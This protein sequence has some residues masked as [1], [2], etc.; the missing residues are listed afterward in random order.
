MVVLQNPFFYAL[1]AL[2]GLCMSSLWFSSKKLGRSWL[3][4]ATCVAIFA[5]GRLL[6]PMPFVIQPRLE[7]SGVI[8]NVVGWPLLI[9]G[10]LL[11]LTAALQIKPVTAPDRKEPLK[12]TGLYGIVRH[13]I[14]VGET[15]WPLGLS[16]LM[17]STIGMALTPFWFLCLYMGTRVEEEQMEELVGDEY[18]EYKRRVPGFIPFLK[19]LTT[20]DEKGGIG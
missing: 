13:P 7:I 11:C 20:K 6:L 12:T 10:L 17:A 9:L 19:S 18:R 5:I 16:I 2:F 8:A 3:Y 14:I 15:L 4:G 1:I